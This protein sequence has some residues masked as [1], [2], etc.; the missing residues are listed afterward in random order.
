M[1][2]LVVV[3][4]NYVHSYLFQPSQRKTVFFL[5]AAEQ[6]RGCLP[7]CTHLRCYFTAQSSIS[8]MGSLGLSFLP[9]GLWREGKGVGFMCWEFWGH[10]LVSKKRCK[11]QCFNNK[12]QTSPEKWFRRLPTGTVA[13]QW[14]LLILAVWDGGS[15]SW[16][17][18][19]QLQ[20]QFQ[21]MYFWML[22]QYHLQEKLSCWMSKTARLEI[23]LKAFYFGSSY[24]RVHLSKS[25]YLMPWAGQAVWVLLTVIYGE[26]HLACCAPILL[27]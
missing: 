26:M 19:C 15:R 16:G 12:S 22:M 23:M 24:S 1:F 7:V 2:V 4:L 13:H 9:P 3:C 8:H 14:A 6:V 18:L 5:A 10:L 11:V 27:T 20:S 21:T 25:L 17:H